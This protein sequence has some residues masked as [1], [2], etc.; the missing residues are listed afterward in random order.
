MVITNG[1][2]VRFPYTPPFPTAAPA[3]AGAAHTHTHTELPVHGDPASSLPGE[4][5]SGADGS[6]SAGA[7]H[8]RSPSTGR[9]GPA[10]PSWEEL[11]SKGGAVSTQPPAQ[12]LQRSSPCAPAQQHGAEG[13]C[14]CCW[15]ACTEL[16]QEPTPRPPPHAPHPAAWAEVSAGGVKRLS[17]SP[18]SSI[19]P[20]LGV[21]ANGLFLVP[22][23]VISACMMGN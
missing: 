21:A 12:H 16:G 2:S 8:G 22:P 6:Q 13:C 17:A 19:H 15:G 7:A 3:K 1:P 18:G 4:R 14:W 5:E 23:L 9:R 20:A 11:R 10:A